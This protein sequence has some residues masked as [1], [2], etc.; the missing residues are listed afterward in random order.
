MIKKI[1]TIAI[2]T[3]S[4]SITAENTPEKMMEYAGENIQTI[5]NVPRNLFDNNLKNMQGMF[6]QMMGFSG[7]KKQPD[8]N[9]ERRIVNEIEDSIME[10]DVEPLVLRNGNRIFSIYTE[11]ETDKAKGGVIIM[12]NRGY[13]ANW[14]TVVKPLR[15]DLSKKGWNTLSI[16]MPV[17]NKSAKYYDYVPIFAYAHPRIQAAISFLKSQGIKKII[18]IGHGCGVHMSMDYI[19]KYSDKEI[20]GFVG[21]GMG[22]TDYKQK[23]KH[24][25]PLSEM[26][27]PILDIY[28]END[29]SGV[30]RLAKQRS[31]SF[32]RFSHSKTKQMIV[33]GAGHYYKK[34]K[35]EKEL[36][37]KISTWLDK[38]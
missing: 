31:Q 38:L 9:R 24:P 18:L 4:M 27:V 33:K 34:P 3:F 16:Q 29:F 7:Q 5:K 21:I 14:E 2:V 32:A 19:A 15:I 28:G 35:A 17:L 13:H 37:I 23:M 30:K 8:F 20:D 22:A 10:G 1:L 36:L 6:G 12:H 11:S 26:S 25:L